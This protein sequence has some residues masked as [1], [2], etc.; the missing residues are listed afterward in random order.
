MH[1][2]NFTLALTCSRGVKSTNGQLNVANR[3]WLHNIAATKFHRHRQ[4]NRQRQERPDTVVAYM[5][6]TKCTYT[7]A[8]I[9][10]VP[11]K[12]ISLKN[13]LRVWRNHWLSGD[14]H[15]FS[16]FTPVLSDIQISNVRLMAVERIKMLLQ[17]YIIIHM[18]LSSY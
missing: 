5:C 15:R 6:T 13:Q 18:L 3:N 7:L 10:K 9:T 17:S 11:Y 8:F 4:I 1:H 16:V 14:H 12:Y 2:K